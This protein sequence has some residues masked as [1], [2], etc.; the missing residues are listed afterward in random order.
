MTK[1]AEEIS[2]LNEKL[3]S[4]SE[5][6]RLKS[7]EIERLTASLRSKSELEDNIAKYYD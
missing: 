2:R 4:K 5:E 6:D 7:Q 1:M 3:R